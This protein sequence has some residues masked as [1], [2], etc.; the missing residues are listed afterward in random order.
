MFSFYL[1]IYLF[2][3][4]SSNWYQSIVR[5]MWRRYIWWVDWPIY[6]YNL[7]NYILI[8]IYN[9]YYHWIACGQSFLLANWS[10]NALWNSSNNNQTR[11]SSLNVKVQQM[12]LKLNSQRNA[13][14]I[15]GSS[16]LSSSS[17]SANCTCI[18]IAWHCDSEIDCLDASDEIGCGK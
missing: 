1:Y 18:P 7:I 15:N 6:K 9:I 13:Q 10:S 8:Y 5:T 2:N 11:S 17:F 14:V 16:T 12:L 3:R 4:M